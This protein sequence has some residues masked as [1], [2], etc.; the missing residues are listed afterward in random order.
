MPSVQET[1]S[2]RRLNH[3]ELVYA[4]GERQLAARVFGLLGCRVED[5]GGTFLTAYVEQAEADIA[6]NVMYAS[7]VTAEQWAFEQ[8]LSSALKQAGTLGDT[9]RGYQGR[10]SS[11]PQ[12][13][14]HFGI[15]FSRYNAYE[16][17]LAKIRRVDEDD[18][19]LKGRV[20]LS[21]VFRP[22][23]PGAYSKIMI[24]AFVRTDV[25]ASGMLS[26]GQHIELQWQ[27][28]RV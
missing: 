15:R 19:Q 17:T 11:E 10:L 21:G 3:V 7:E 9:A 8:A 22:G 28:P 14:C 5:R 16:A 2:L 18:P 20:T 26:L 1:P 27:L 12:R 4:P 13:S 25:I 24:Q 6:N 23:D